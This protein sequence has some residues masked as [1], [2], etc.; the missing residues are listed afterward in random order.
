MSTTPKT[1]KALKDPERRV[2]NLIHLCRRMEN[3]LGNIQTVIDGKMDTVDGEDG[4]PQPND[5]M[6]ISSMIDEALR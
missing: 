1:D 5:Y 4:T 6:T 2:E 3:A